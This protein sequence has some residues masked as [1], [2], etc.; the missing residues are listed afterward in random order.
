MEPEREDTT[1]YLKSRYSDKKEPTL[2]L[3]LQ[4]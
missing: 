2:R 1:R 3:A 4:L